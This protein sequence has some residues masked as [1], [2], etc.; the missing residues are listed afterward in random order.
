MYNEVLYKKYLPKYIARNIGDTIFVTFKSVNFEIFRKCL[1]S[2]NFDANYDW[3][4]NL[5]IFKS[6]TF[7]N[8]KSFVTVEVQ[9]QYV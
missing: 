7:E 5:T 1:E 2:V 9:N 4:K 6:N 3:H 8:Y